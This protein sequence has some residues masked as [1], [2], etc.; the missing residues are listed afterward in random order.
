[1][2]NRFFLRIAAVFALIAAYAP[3]EAADQEPRHIIAPISREDLPRVLGFELPRDNAPPEGWTGAPVSTISS[4]IRE[5]HGGRASVRIERHPGD[6]SA[7]SSVVTFIPVDFHADAIELRGFLRTKDVEGFAGLW[8]REDG[9]LAKSLAFDNMQARHIN[10]TTDWT[11]YS[12][13]LPLRPEARELVFGALLSGSGTAWADDL[14]LLVDGKPVWEVPHVEIPKTAIERDREFDAGSKVA[15]DAL[16]SQQIDALFVLAKVWGF[17][18]Y[19]HPTVT[20]G[21]RNWDY[22]LFRVLP[23]VLA[24]QNHA[25]AMAVIARWV[26]RLGPI[27]SCSPCATLDGNEIHLKPNLKWMTAP[28]LGP[29]L[30]RILH[31]AYANRS[32]DDKQFYVARAPVGNPSFEH[33][34]PYAAFKT[35]DAGVQLL[36]LFR[37]WNIVEYWSPYRNLIA[38]WDKVLRESI[39]RIALAKSFDDYELQLMRA[40]AAMQDTHANLWSSLQV[41]PPVGE[42]ELPVILRYVEDRF[43]VANYASD[44]LAESSGLRI[45]DVI[46]AID[47]VPVARL[48]S[49]V[50]DYYADSNEAA[51][52]RDIAR[53]LSH[54]S[55]GIVPIK[56]KRG[57]ETLNVESNRVEISKLDLTRDRLHDLSGEAFRVL[58]EGIG[59]L[60]L[61]SVKADQIA[62]YLKSATDTKGLIIDIRNYP[63]DYVVFALGSY[64]VQKATPFVR[65]T[66]TDPVNPGVFRWQ[67]LQTLTP[68]A[69]F[70]PGKV[71]V[72][73]D[74]ISQS[75]AEYTAMAL[76]AAPNTVVMGSTTA[77]ADGNVS[78]FPMPGNLSSMISGMGVFYPD[79]R[80]TQRVGIV[81]DITVRPTI[82]GIR[83]GRDEVL[84]SAIHY[85]Q[86]R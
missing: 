42:C 49:R 67:A 57:N 85:I 19:H 60:K 66:G 69:P 81:P 77:G 3:L 1:V 71:V 27:T 25:Q 21:Q 74:E 20:S 29:E 36:S 39:P 26:E 30:V 56:L 48:V 54:G 62:E 55:C 68:E 79:K 65:N 34:L 40:I 5:V 13:K 11:R 43:V 8:L 32:T 6:P 15:L 35:T 22:D 10:G 47:G 64:L 70:F 38:D 82:A 46:N 53:S 44:E 4:D 84:D 59:Y 51:R 37:F 58:P 31:S 45:G 18:K 16:S 2:R 72:L 86:S 23:G 76:R 73:V 75:Q 50:A 78:R 63:S 12:I 52:Y 41:R 7:F 28:D 80:P 14:E 33:E 9:T 17:L 61:S 24:T 83:A